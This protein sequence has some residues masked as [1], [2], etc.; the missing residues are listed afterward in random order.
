MA[1]KMR[2]LWRN[3]ICLL[4]ANLFGVGYTPLCPGTAAS[5]VGVAVFMLWGGTAPVYILVT[6][7]SVIAAFLCSSHAERIYGEKDS[8]HI[9]IDDFS[10]ML[11]T[12]LSFPFTVPFAFAGFFLFRM[13]DMLKVP[14][15]DRVEKCHGARGIVGDDII[16]A[17][18]ANILLQ[19][20]RFIIPS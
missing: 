1:Q 19:A 14:P 17:C 16:A 5:V 18:Y 6:V 11:V 4:I 20:A 10:G 7:A 9:V 15:A 13:F 3:I 2:S 8:K 12:F